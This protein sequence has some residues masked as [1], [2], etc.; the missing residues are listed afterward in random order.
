MK[1]KYPYTDFEVIEQHIRRA[2]IE[3]AVVVSRM[4]VDGIDA[5]ARG[6]RSLK[7]SVEASFQRVTA[8]RPANPNPLRASA[9]Y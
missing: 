6:L 1:T 2:R 8:R 3:R 7:T 5:I 4:I 9:R